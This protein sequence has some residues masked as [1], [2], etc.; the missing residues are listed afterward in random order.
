VRSTLIHIP[1]A[2]PL[3]GIPIFG[4]GW[5]LAIVLLIGVVLLGYRVYREGWKRDILADI[6]ILLVFAAVVGWLAPLLEEPSASGPPAGIPIRAYGVMVLLGIGAGIAMSMWQARR[7]G[8]DPEIVFSLCFWLVAAGFVGARTFYVLQHWEQFAGPSVRE[9]VVRIVN[10]TDGGLVVYGSFLGAS[11]ACVGYVL[12]HRLPLL[13]L[14]DLLAPGLMIGLALGRIGCLMN[15]CCWG[16]VCDN[17]S[18][19]I[20][21]P[22]GSPPFIDQLER[23]WLVGMRTHRDPVTDQMAVY[24]VTPNGLAAQQGLQVGDV[25]TAVQLPDPGQFHRMRSG[26][27]VADA[28]FSLRLKDG[29]RI[30]W[31]FGQLPS[32]SQRVYPAQLISSITGILICLFLWSCYPFRRRDGEIFALL[33]TIYPVL[34]ILEEMIRSDEPSVLSTD[35]R[36]TISQTV[37][38]ILLV[39]T[40]ALWWYV[41]S[42]PKGSVLPPAAAVRGGCA[43]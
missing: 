8:V 32:R 18:L 6:P 27:T 28:E 37:S 20:T 14:A 38:S 4:P 2:D 10:L 36:W 15:G 25:I 16:G 40:V 1:H 35:F 33:V 13:A 22:Q 12:K 7:M 39:L 26:Q 41:L 43:A 19:G 34:R 29:R 42:R 17:S 21:F 3:W 11:L 30:T 5:L 31:Q 9:T 24:E 23:G